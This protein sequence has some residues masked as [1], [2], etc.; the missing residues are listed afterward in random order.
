MT[1]VARRQVPAELISGA[2]AETGLRFTQSQPH[3]LGALLDAVHA[4]DLLPPGP[5]N[6]ARVR[7]TGEDQSDIE[8]CSDQSSAFRPTRLRSH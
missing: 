5:Q 6:H 4:S 1:S 2:E 3:R 8:A 7:R